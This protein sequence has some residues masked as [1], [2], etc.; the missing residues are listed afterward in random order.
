VLDTAKDCFNF[1]TT[2]FEPIN[3]SATHIYH[4]ALEQSPH[5][6][7][8][9][10]VYYHQ[11]LTPFPRMAVG[12][13]DVWDQSIALST[14]RYQ[15]SS[16]TWSPCGQ[17]IAIQTEEVVDIRDPLTFELLSTLQPT[18][19][20]SQLTGTPAYSPD[21]HSL[22]CASNTTIIIWDIQTG[23]VAKEI[24]CGKAHKDSLVWSLDGGL[25]GT[26]VWAQSTHTLTVHSYDIVSGMAQSPFTLQSQDKPYLW[27][28]NK[29]LPHLWANK[30]SLLHLRAHDKSLPHLW[31]RDKSL[32]HPWAHNK[33][34]LVMTTV[35]DG[36]ACTINISEVG[37]AP[38]KTE[39]FPIQLMEG[40]HQIGSFSPTTSRISIS[41]NGDGC[42]LLILDI[43]N[44]KGLLYEEGD[45]GSHCF[46]SDGSLFA[47]SS[48]EGVY[49]WK[50]D[51][52]HYILWG[53]LP[54]LHDSHLLFSP[55]SLSI[56]G[57]DQHIFRLLR[58][59]G[60]YS[61]ST[62]QHHGIISH[63][64]TYAATTHYR[65][66]TVAITNLLSRT[67]PQL[68]DVGGEIEGLVLTG[69]ILLVGCS[70]MVMAWLLT[71]EGVVNDLL[72]D[73]EAGHNNS[74]W[75]VPTSQLGD[76]MF[77]VEGETGAI[78]SGGGIL[79]VY[80]TRTGE[81]LKPAQ[82]P[83][84]SNGPWYSLKDMMQA[85]HHLSSSSIYGVPLNDNCKPPQT[86]LEEGWVKDHEGKH[87]LWLPVEWRA[88]DWGEMEWFTDSATMQ[89][90]SQGHGSIIIKL[91]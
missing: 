36:K 69:N 6:S 64:G 39:S 49:I 61:T 27:A 73:R 33:S 59:D 80:N 40:D 74:I 68:I 76:L 54:F 37:P 70:R 11:H 46:S 65:G 20:A 79:C 29:S 17:F 91:Y 34:F 47:A 26:M 89:F 7:I 16:V 60:S 35:G 30:K 62:T 15:R 66:G 87:L 24:E 88:V 71:G 52:G 1:V 10:E 77:S 82:A 90:V 67:P 78:K 4:S 81:V 2:F 19:P 50:Y 32:P 85:G 8:I 14:T 83:L 75:T 57:Q 56:L 43:W 22:A 48:R 42:Q 63:C 53:G 12:I 18:K 44:S 55:T 58:L 5:L 25:I 23:G 3:V 38:T 45:F 51:N 72:G 86:A 13:P 41:I 28:H 84:Y 21:G 31:T 9:Q